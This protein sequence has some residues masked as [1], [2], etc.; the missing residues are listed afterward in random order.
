MQTVGKLLKNSNRN[1]IYSNNRIQMKR[2][3]TLLLLMLLLLAV[4]P[5]QAQTDTE[6]WFAIPKLSQ[7]HD[8]GN[9][10]FFFRF[11]TLNLPATI[12]ISMPANPAFEPMVFDVAANAALTVPLAAVNAGD[13]F[14]QMW[15]ENPNQVYNRGILITATNLITA[16]FEVGTNNNPDIFSLKGHN[17]LGLDFFVPFQ[18]IHYNQ[19]LA[20]RPYSAIYIVA[21]TDDTQ[22]LV[23]PTRPVFPG[24]P[25][26]VPF[27]LTL[28]RGQ[29]IALAPD[30]YNGVGNLAENHLGGTRVQSNKPIAIATS[31]DSVRG[32]PGGCYDLIGDQ[33]I[34]THIIG[35]E[36]IAMRGR[37]TIPENFYVLA[38]QPDTDVFIDGDSIIRLQP[39]EMYRY[40]FTNQTHFIR[41]THP[42]YVYHVAGFGCEQGGAVLPPINVCTGSTQVSF[43]RSLAGANG[44]F[45]LNILVRA[46]AQ[47]GFVFNGDG[48]NTKIKAADFQ[49]V[50]GTTKWLAAEYEFSNVADVPLNAASLIE[51]IKDV[52]HLGIINGGP[53]SGT[54]Y[55]YF[56]DFNEL[57]VKANIS[58]TGALHKT[59][60]GQ[61]VQLV[62]RGGTQYLWHPP[63]YLDDPTS[64]TPVSLPE[65][66]IK[67]VV[68]VSGACQMIDSTSVFIEVADPVIAA[69][70]VDEVV[71]CAPFTLHV[72]NESVG[73]S[74][75]SWRMGDGTV[76]TT[77][78]QEFHHTYN[79]PTDEPIVR[80]L[81]LVGRN[82]LLCRDTLITNITVYPEISAQASANIISGC[83][84]LE[85]DFS[86][87]SH[88][89]ETYTWRF[90]DGNSSTQEAPTHIFH[91]YSKQDTIFTVVLKARSR[92]GCEDTD[93]LYIH[94]KP[95]I[96]TGFQIDPPNHCNPYPA[97]FTNTSFGADLS[98]W[99]FDGGLTFENIE[100][101]HFDKYF[102]NPSFVDPKNYEVWLISENNY[103]CADTLIRPVTVYPHITAD[104][105]AS[106]LE[107][108]NPLPV[109]FT[110]QSNGA[111]TFLWDFDG[112]AGSSSS[113]S[114]FT[115]L[116]N[117][118]TTD[119]AVYNVRLTAVSQYLCQDEKVVQMKVYP[120]IEA[121]F[122]FD[123]TSYCTPQEITFQ[124]TSAGGFNYYWD[125]GNGNTSQETG[126]F[127]VQ[128]YINLSPDL[129]TYPVQLV[130]ENASGCKDTLIREVTIYPQVKADFEMIT[131]GCHPLEVSFE[132]KSWGASA[133]FWDFGDG[134]NSQQDEPLRIFTNTDHYNI[135]TYMV[136]L[137]VE[138]QFGCVDSLERQI[139]VH[140]KP[141]ADYTVSKRTGC[142]PLFVNFA[143]TSLGA[144]SFLWNFGD[145]SQ[146]VT[147]T[148]GVSHTYFNNTSE[149]ISFQTR[150]IATNTEYGCKDT[151]YNSLTVYPQVVASVSV[152]DFEGCHPL[153]VT[154]TN[155]TQGGASPFL[156]NY[157]D[158]NSSTTDSTTH[159]YVFSNFSHTHDQPFVVKLKAESEFGCK[160]STQVNILVYPRPKA[161]FQPDTVVGCSPLLVSF[162]DAS[163]GSATWRWN[164]GDG[165]TS[166]QNWGNT[167]NEYHQAHDQGLGVFT[168]LLEIENDRGCIDT[169][170][171]QITVYPDITADF[172]VTTE[173][174]HPLAV[175]FENLS[176]GV[177]QH[178]WSLGDGTIVNT[179]DPEYIY[180]NESYTQNKVYQVNLHTLSQW[181][182][183]AS[184]SLPIT[185][186]PRP[187]SDFSLNHTFGCSPLEVTIENHSVGG[188]AFQW[189]LGGTP[190]ANGQINFDHTFRNL[191]EEPVVL[192]LTL[193]TSN[194]FGCTR[195]SQQQIT[196]FPEVQALFTADN[197]IMAGCNPLHLQFQNQSQRAHQYSWSFGDGTASTAS[198]PA[199]VFYTGS[200]Q[201]SFYN[202]LLE[203][204]STFGCKDTISKQVQVYPVPVADLFVTPHSQTYPNTS[205]VAHNLSSDGNWQYIW[206]LGDGTQLAKLDKSPVF[207][208][209]V[210]EPGDYATR[211]YTVRLFAGNDFCNDTISQKVEVLAPFPIVGFE[212]SAQ[213]CPPLEVQFR[214]ETEYG[215]VF[216]WDFAD[217]NF[218]DLEHPRHIFHDPGEYLV[219][220]LVSGEGG[221]DS[222]YQTIT[223]FEPPTADFRVT[224]PVVQLP[225]ESVRMVNLSSLAAYYEWHMGD[226][227]VYYEFEPE[228]KYEREGNY[229]ITLIVGSDTQPQCFDQIT[230]AGAVMA[231]ENCR[232]I[233][234]NAFT[235]N[236]TGP[237]GGQY[238]V[239]DPANNVFYP[240][241]TGV[242]EYRLEIYNRWGEFLFR[243]TDINIGWDGY[244]R[245]E[246]SPMGVYVWKVWV[247]C[248]SGKKIEDIGDVTL[249][250]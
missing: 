21:T 229:D 165:Q 132:N 213:G 38:T 32:L 112:A 245:G 86:N 206:D 119:T 180:Y 79:N 94:V 46:G 158:G 181:G 10:K 242:R 127:V 228:H 30:N 167:E 154:F 88:G 168:A 230:K 140:P 137:L 51:N 43:T 249:Y 49:V 135:Q 34:P 155:N 237:T 91:N 6:F 208:N 93:T 182:C 142:A 83:A 48:P 220:L 71:G 122:T 67:Y 2:F 224:P 144:N 15:N 223:V 175:Q 97:T 150:L 54:M 214:N 126:E 36:Y 131:S 235:P 102:D 118:S 110:N 215:K 247:T 84:P 27:T 250:R 241:H 125:F 16:Y 133:F 63:D 109:Q 225:Y 156:W 203:A 143:E 192:D 216:L 138:S 171:R 85:V 80:Q 98:R 201:E 33:I 7:S 153:E 186:W 107:G 1:L 231:E 205:V 120:R 128:E 69:Y 82:P 246:L 134:G 169:A 26:G 195:Q 40:L 28:H 221:V 129:V 62:A 147:T 146:E 211:Y 23:T 236:T 172:N 35:T 24:R 194:G 202:V 176:L 161:Q 232:I 178:T 13:V 136:K 61:P 218:S 243:S 37:L 5:A 100:D 117:P 179:S 198:N 197:S 41:T 58:G 209:Y 177:L 104:F 189:N 234:P 25:A 42:S 50:P 65:K 31:D 12:T 149:A 70:T 59:C 157:G 57:D 238:V 207:H 45:F 185:V 115:W 164:F 227:T 217:G 200:T 68:T 87:F 222:A 99:S 18:N 244:Y 78:A 60:F 75:Y 123:Y 9:R 191:E 170:S 39:G 121:S 17:A 184:R 74:N 124:N 174:C 66:H 8:W 77:S 108:C 56:S 248:H 162:A 141:K 233:F 81:M 111:H 76:Y 64:A 44:R 95:Y 212:P 187:K 19:P 47:D 11:A 53:S 89:A 73:V 92:F 199:N 14:F 72:K 163:V 90:G 148:G 152:S 183:E 20:T 105:S 166:I 113:E 193:V 226:G 114:P 204:R 101:T 29:S 52:F 151:L 130:I 139:T 103:G 106:V 210:W 240:I 96:E 22:I 173:G 116:H 3:V 4:R 160:D 190:S 55:G 196:V 145:G 219:K 239:N 188:S 159:T